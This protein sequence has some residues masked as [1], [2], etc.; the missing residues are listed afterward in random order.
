MVKLIRDFRRED[1]EGSSA[2]DGDWF[3]KG[4][5]NPSGGD[6]SGTGDGGGGAGN[7]G[8]NA[9]AAG[10]AS[11]GAAG[12]ANTPTEEQIKA[13][14]D[15][16]DSLVAKGEANLTPEEKA[17]LA[18]IQTKYSIT[19][20]D[21]EG[22]PISDEELKKIT[23]TANRIKAIQAKPEAQRTLEEVKFLKDNTTQE[24]SLYEQVDQ[25]TG[26]PV[27]VD[28]GDVNPLSPEGVVKREAAIREQAINNYEELLKQELPL[29]YQFLLH[30]QAGGSPET[31]FS[32]NQDDY[33][34]INLTKEDKA[35][36]ESTYRK[37][38]HVKGIDQEQVD[39]LVK[40]A[41]DSGKL[42]ELSE[43]E[44]NAAKARQKAEEV[45]REATVKQQRIAEAK[46]QEQFSAQVTNA[47]TKGIA[48]VTIPATD[49]KAFEDYFLGNMY[50]R[51]GQLIMYKPVKLEEL[52]EELASAYFRYKK[53]DLKALVERRAGT[54]NVEQKQ[55]SI[56]VRLVPRAADGSSTKL[57]KVPMSQV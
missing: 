16:Y 41:K 47:I 8:G 12:A 10:A 30:Q 32:M 53:G 2:Y 3:S 15:L 56:K 4:K 37:L 25:L 48:G 42:F 35:T 50:I 5:S 19:K 46:L 52:N 20:T 9:V 26:A 49:R 11:A 21:A 18:E 40:A 43:K 29:A 27:V 23:E 54:L 22:N 45:N 33:L 34:S 31:F 57:T 55:K 7:G 51:Q 14:T 28:Y 6:G 1:G 17:K 24:P 36:Q 44:L 38:L 39:V 13:D